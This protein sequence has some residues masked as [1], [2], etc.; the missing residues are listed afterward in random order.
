MGFTWR[1]LLAWLGSGVICLWVLAGVAQAEATSLGSS[2]FSGNALVIPGGEGLVGDQTAEVEAARR[3]TPEAVVARSAS[4]SAYEGLGTQA[5][6]R[7]ANEIFASVVNEPAGGPPRLP[8]GQKILAYL[9]ANAASLEFPGGLRGVVYSQAPIAAEVSAGQDVPID[10]GLAHTASGFEPKQPVAG[11]HVRI[12]NVLAEG[13]SLM[14]TGVS[15]TPVNEQGVPLGGSEG[16]VDGASV[17]YGDT[18]APGVTDVDT[19]VKPT[20]FGL[21]IDTIL[22]SQRSPERSVF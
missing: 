21:S 22:R 9:S 13:P 2:S 12:P 18:E 14:G 5:A 7:V 8:S 1:V 10:L 11:V 16:G 19:I 17:F 6:E 20:T 4:S 15:L 3:A